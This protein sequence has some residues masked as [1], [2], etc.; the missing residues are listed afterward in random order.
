MSVPVQDDSRTIVSIC[1][2]TCCLYMLFSSLSVYMYRRTVGGKAPEVSVALTDKEARD[3][4]YVSLKCSF[5]GTAFY[6]L[7]VIGFL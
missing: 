6:I 3:G 2:C 5:T 4:E 7:I 1:V